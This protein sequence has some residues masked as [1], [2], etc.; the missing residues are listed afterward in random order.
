MQLLKHIIDEKCKAGV[1]IQDR[2]QST[3]GTVGVEM[4]SRLGKDG[5]EGKA[6]QAELHTPSNADPKKSVTKEG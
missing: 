4:L 5:G 3:A 6:G 2:G 1:I